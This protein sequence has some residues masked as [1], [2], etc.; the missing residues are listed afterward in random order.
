MSD[1]SV[2]L[3]AVLAALS[4]AAGAQ[5]E[6]QECSSS[7]YEAYLAAVRSKFYENWKPPKYAVALN[8]RVLI[9]QNFRGEVLY[10]GTAKCTEDPTVQKSV[11]DAAYQASPL[12]LPARKTCFRRDV[13]LEIESRLPDDRG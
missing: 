9:K 2:F 4:A 3:A 5:E 6:G 1:K 10:V 7:D 11:V 12:P 8:C 13:I